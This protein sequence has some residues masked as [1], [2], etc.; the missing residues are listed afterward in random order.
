MLFGLKNERSV[1]LYGFV[2]S[3]IKNLIDNGIGQ[4]AGQAAAAG[5]EFGTIG[6][7]GT[8]SDNRRIGLARCLSK[9]G[10]CSRSAAFVLIR[11][12][13]VK[14]N[15]ALCR[16]PEAPVR[17]G[18]D[19]IQVEGQTVEKRHKLYLVLNKPRGVV[20]TAA[21]EKG[22]KTVIDYVGKGIPHVGPVG[23]LDKASEGLLLLTNDSE[24]AASLLAP[25]THLPRTYHV[26]VS[27]VVEGALLASLQNGAKIGNDHLRVQ[28]AGIL[29]RGEKNTWLEIV[30]DEGKNRHIRRLLEH[31]GMEVLRLV[32]VA[33][34]PLELGK[35][36][37]GQSRD[38]T[39]IE[40]QMLDRAM[41]DSRRRGRN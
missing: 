41:G 27:V 39:S 3:A 9:L 16:N 30:L 26:Q 18:K 19:K 1:S 21:D 28:S 17:L 37:K 40:K 25:E 12:G 20:T 5:R 13:R 7:V 36:A 33:I 31:F 4:T 6:D 2:Y 29:R 34:G 8:S 14:L 22:R 38:L 35:L 11:D 10:H 24:W 23:R 32:R 15:G